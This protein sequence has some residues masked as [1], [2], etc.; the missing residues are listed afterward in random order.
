MERNRDDVVADRVLLDLLKRLYFGPEHEPNSCP[1]E[2]AATESKRFESSEFGCVELEP[3]FA[4]HGASS[5]GYAVEPQPG[6]NIPYF[7]IGGPAGRR[8]G[9]D[10][11]VQSTCGCVGLVTAACF[12]LDSSDMD[13]NFLGV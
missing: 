8:Q 2:A 9:L 3:G 7:G 10:Q 13:A 5:F 4:G 6:V 12:H 11:L 1:F